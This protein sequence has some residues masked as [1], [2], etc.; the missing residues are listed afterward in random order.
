MWGEWF[1][2]IHEVSSGSVV[3]ENCEGPWLLYVPALRE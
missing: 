2:A 1:T 3:V